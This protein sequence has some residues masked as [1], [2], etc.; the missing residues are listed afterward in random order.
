MKRVIASVFLAGLSLSFAQST[1]PPPILKIVR[2]NMK[3]GTGSA[4][5]KIEAAY[6]HAFAPT[7]FANY[8]GWEAITGSTQ[9]WFVEGYGSYAAI[10][11]AS[12]IANSEPLKTTLAPLEVQDGELRTGESTLFA[13]YAKDLSYYGTP[14][15]LGRTHFVWLNIV[16]LRRGHVE[17]YAELRK[18]QNAA[19]VKVGAKWSRAVYVIGN[20]G[21]ATDYLVMWPMESLSDMDRP[22]AW[23]NRDAL[24]ESFERYRKLNADIIVSTEE[25]IFAVNPKMSNPSK[26][27]IEAD[28]DF[29]TPKAK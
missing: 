21:S 25:I 29:W 24:G 17:D 3:P 18:I 2:E 11:E 22:A 27:F 5:E 14:L 13:H 12:K 1:E 6:A 20:G 9:A 4:H 8:M 26:A 28:P 15:N 16:H 7:K 19:F 23:N 10:E